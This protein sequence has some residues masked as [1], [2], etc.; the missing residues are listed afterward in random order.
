MSIANGAGGGAE[1][2]DRVVDW[3]KRPWVVLSLKGV[4]LVLLVWGVASLAGAC[5]RRL[6][7][8]QS[9]RMAEMGVGKLEGDRGVARMA[10]ETA[11]RLDGGNARALRLLAAIEVM[12]GR[13]GKAMEVYGRLLE[14]GG[15][16]VVDVT[17]YAELASRM[18]E[19]VLA[20]RLAGLVERRGAPG[21]SN[22]LRAVELARQGRDSEALEEWR[23]ALA[24]SGSDV[25]RM[26]MANFLMQRALDEADAREA[27][28][29]LREVAVGGGA[30]AVEACVAGLLSGYVA[31]GERADWV[32]MLR[33]ASG[34]VGRP[35][36]VADAMEVECDPSS[37]ERVAGGVIERVRGGG[38]GERVE[39]G[40]WLVLHGLG[41]E[42][43]GLVAIEEGLGDG[44]AYR[45]CVQAALDMGRTDLLERLLGSDVVPVGEVER[46]LYRARA[47]GLAGGDAGVGYWRVL[48]GVRTRGEVVFAAAYLAGVGETGVLMD[49]L[50]GVWEDGGM[51]V[52][53]LEG[54]LP[55]MADRDDV[56]GMIALMEM[57]CEVPGFENDPGVAN[58][59]AH[60]RLVAGVEVDPAE[61]GGRLEEFPN[62]VGVAFTHALALLR[63]GREAEALAV[64]ERPGMRLHALDTSQKAIM[65]CVLAANGDVNRAGKLLGFL[66]RVRLTS[67][68]RAMLEEWMGGGRGDGGGG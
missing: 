33:A 18:G 48:E 41:G 52:P 2:S 67:E 64:V 20:G 65:A 47:A 68:E 44:A 36:L 7:V 61:T 27:L 45:L 59:L 12:D 16:G 32:A 35:G 15:A 46:G 21:F 9:A 19:G 66:K 17:L 62:D 4:V 38:L 14:G 39:A 63:A 5:I 60:A 30:M 3:W 11:L 40:H 13:E 56:G 23:V 26:G 24:K 8:W 37:L 51:V 57:A 28:E 6:E 22:R 25:D 43:P 10:A 58:G 42:V 55:V 50:R 53:V 1:L 31:A 29:L 54:V 49:F 34:S